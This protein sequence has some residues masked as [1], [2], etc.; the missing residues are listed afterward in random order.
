MVILPL[1]FFRQMCAGHVLVSIQGWSRHSPLWK[2]GKGPAHKVRGVTGDRRAVPA[3]DAVIQPEWFKISYLKICLSGNLHSFFNPP[4][5]RSVLQ[6]FENSY[7]TSPTSFFSAPFSTV[8]RSSLTFPL[9]TQFVST[10]HKT[11]VGTSTGC[12]LSI[13]PISVLWSCYLT[14]IR[15]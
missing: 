12:Q 2:A 11:P 3:C 14:W 1:L 15:Y 8:W 10:R 5:P 13:Q 6:G 4:E 9:E 7:V